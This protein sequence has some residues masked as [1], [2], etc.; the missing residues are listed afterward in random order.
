[1]AHG[2]RQ[3][4]VSVH[5]KIKIEYCLIQEHYKEVCHRRIKTILEAGGGGILGATPPSW[6]AIKSCS[7]RSL[8]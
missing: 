6:Y 2:K 3:P 5:K 1:M 8:A 7:S 4:I